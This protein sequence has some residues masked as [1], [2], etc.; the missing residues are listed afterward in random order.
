MLPVELPSAPPEPGRLCLVPARP[1]PLGALE[2]LWVF[3]GDATAGP[4]ASVDGLAAGLLPTV[5]GRRCLR[6]FHFNDLH[7]Y[8]TLPDA[9]HGDSRLFAQIVRRHRAARRDAAG[10]E[11]VLLLS[12]GDDH[13]GTAL[14]ELLGWKPEDLIVDPAY[15]AYSAAG[16]D[17]ATLGNHELDRGGAVLRAGI[18]A[19]AAFPIL[20]ANLLGGAELTASSDY[21]PA[22]IALAKG[23]RFGFVGLTTTV[24]TR[25]HT[26]LD[27]GLAVASPLTTLANLL[28]AV[29]EQS[30]IVIVMSHCGYG[31][32]SNRDG[33]AGAVRDLA[34]GDIAIARLAAA[35]TDKPVV[36]M[37]GHT[38]SVLNERGLGPD[39]LIDG[40]PIIQAGGHGSHLGEFDAEIRLG[41]SRRHWRVKATLHPLQRN[42]GGVG[43]AVSPA[44]GGDDGVD[45]EFE[46]E[47]IAPLMR[48]V[49]ARMDEALADPVDDAELSRP[50]TRRQR[51]AGECALANFICDALVARSTDF[52]QEADLAIVNS[53]AF[54]DGLP[55][56]RPV[57]FKDLYNVMPFA[58]CL[59]VG[60]IRGGELR[61]ILRNNAKRIVRPEELAGAAPID[62]NGYV[63]RGFL[64]FSGALRYAIRLAR[65]AEETT[66]EAVTI[67]GVPL[68][69]MLDRTFR[70]VFTN[71]LGAGGYGECWNGKP[72][73]AGVPGRI[74][75]FDF[76]PLPKV[77]TGLV[78]RNEV[79]AFVRSVGRIAADTGARRDGRLTLL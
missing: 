51:Y 15:S 53:T 50:A 70:V 68:E 67:G 49:R 31:V 17:A 32:E 36:V 42:S 10:D 58:D 54:G 13:T 8:L 65:S 14:D 6:L 38:H 75:G 20:S 16:V 44:A 22:A 43:V 55:S 25:T 19:S 1:N 24:D 52:P 61:D 71:Y 76:R 5:E 41:H 33:K 78:F 48:R 29:A 34:E 47:V 4:I 30:D 79:V 11:V 7:N 62:V 73:G 74:A 27:P 60:E 21:F 9:I 64:H 35:L 40:V 56:G 57:T 39:T 69:R 59:Q 46:V 23:V 18:R 26:S 63:S 3:V 66:V 77:D 2:R 37:G 28:P 12:G 45:V 72:I